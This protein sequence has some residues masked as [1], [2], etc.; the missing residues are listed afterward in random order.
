MINPVEE[1]IIKVTKAHPELQDIEEDNFR[2]F[3]ANISFM[4]KTFLAEQSVT[5][6]RWYDKHY[7]SRLKL[8]WSYAN[9]FSSDNK[10]SP[11]V[12]PLSDIPKRFKDIYVIAWGIM[13]K[14]LE[15]NFPELIER[16]T[17]HSIKPTKAH[18]LV[19]LSAA[20]NK[21]EGGLYKVEAEGNVQGEGVIVAKGPDAENMEV[22]ATI[23]YAK[24]AGREFPIVGSKLEY[25]LIDEED[26]SAVVV[27][28]A[29]K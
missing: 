22:G 8:G 16:V 14:I 18:I 20:S 11:L 17:V 9:E 3:E 21:T 28:K 1:A 27:H 26:V 29:K 7:M 10:T 13:I 5:V 19:V 25:W 24:Y 2:Y 12:A 15:R 23:I 4:I 6:S